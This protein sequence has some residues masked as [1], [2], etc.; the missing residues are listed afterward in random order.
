MLIYVE[1]KFDLDKNNKINILRILLDKDPYIKYNV[2][3][4]KFLLGSQ[5]V[6]IEEEFNQDQIYFTR[7][8]IGSGKKIANG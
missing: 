2:S 3:T 4:R 8:K 6:G 1:W 5:K 7:I